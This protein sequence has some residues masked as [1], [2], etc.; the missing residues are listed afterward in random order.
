[1]EDGMLTWFGH[2]ERMKKRTLTKQIHMASVETLEVEYL[3]VH[4]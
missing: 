4:F 3:G 1:M 2:V